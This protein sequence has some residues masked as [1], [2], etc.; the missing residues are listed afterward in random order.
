MAAA[1]AAPA[2]QFAGLA[3]WAAGEA[4]YPGH[5]EREKVTGEEG[6]ELQRR[7]LQAASGIDAAREER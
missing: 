5:G 6:R 1:L 7:L 4:G 3:A 2:G